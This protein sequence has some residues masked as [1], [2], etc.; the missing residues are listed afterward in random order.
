MRRL[1]GRNT[2]AVA[3]RS[4]T[5]GGNSSTKQ[6][7]A[8]AEI[9]AGPQPKEEKRPKMTWYAAHLLFYVKLKRKRQTRYPVWENMVLIRART[10]DEAF[11][12]AEKRGRDDPCMEPDDTFTWNGVPAEWV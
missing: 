3:R 1:T 12:E 9:R 7:R 2:G 11:A 5:S 4:N 8:G 10:L 6:D